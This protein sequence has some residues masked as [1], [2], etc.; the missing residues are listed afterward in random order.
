MQILIK[1]EVNRN[2][3]FEIFRYEPVALFIFEATNKSY[4][5]KI[6][7]DVSYI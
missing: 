7:S 6:N 3:G 2:I 4:N 1:M 5:L